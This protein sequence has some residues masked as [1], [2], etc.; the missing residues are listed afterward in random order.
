M[1][2]LRLIPLKVF[3]FVFIATTLVACGDDD[4]SEPPAELVEFEPSVVVEE[5]WSASTGSA[6]KQQFLFIEPLLLED[7]IVTAGRDGNV[8]IVDLKDGTVIDEIELE[9]TL[10]GGVGG[11][12]SVWL[13]A[14]RDGELI[15]V[16]GETHTVSWK[17]N[18]PS[19]VLARPVI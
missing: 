18:V 17:V 11:N 12:A 19:E 3:L 1:I 5:V 6:I 15:A 2:R 8:A 7:K 16:D 14:T 9:T 4:N 10:S 13:F